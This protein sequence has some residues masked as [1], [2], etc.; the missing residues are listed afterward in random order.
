M[1]S[2]ATLDHGPDLALQGATNPYCR[3][4]HFMR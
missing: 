4:P 3:D 1:Q 2:V